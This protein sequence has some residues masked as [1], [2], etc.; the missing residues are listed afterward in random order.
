M[1]IYEKRND[2]ANVLHKYEFSLL[3]VKNKIISSPILPK[4]INKITST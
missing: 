1:T 2:G 4:L 3:L